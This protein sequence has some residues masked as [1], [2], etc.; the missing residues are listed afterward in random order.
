MT[1]LRIDVPETHIY[2][3][4]DLRGHEMHSDCWCKPHEHDTAMWTWVHHS[5]DVREDFETG[6]RKKS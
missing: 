2:P 5:M 4:G 1:R 3:I 6:A